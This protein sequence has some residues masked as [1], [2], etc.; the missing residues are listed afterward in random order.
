MVRIHSF[1][2]LLFVRVLLGFSV[3][4]EILISF[5]YFFFIYF[6]RACVDDYIL[7]GSDAIMRLGLRARA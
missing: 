2:H 1:I 5:F 4:N 6:V 7:R 3:F